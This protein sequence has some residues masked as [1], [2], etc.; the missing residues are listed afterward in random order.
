MLL[1]GLK[2]IPSMAF[3]SSLITFKSARIFP[4]KCGNLE[5]TLRHTCTSSEFWMHTH[6]VD[7]HHANLLSV[8]QQ[9]P[10]VPSVSIFHHSHLFLLIHSLSVAALQQFAK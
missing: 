8:L 9:Y 1:M 2:K 10:A 6:T 3:P 5:S 4:A 7:L